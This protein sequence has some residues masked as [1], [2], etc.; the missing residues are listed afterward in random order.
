MNLRITGDEAA[1]LASEACLPCHEPVFEV[2]VESDGIYLSYDSGHD[3]TKD[4][5]TFQKEWKL[6]PMGSFVKPMSMMDPENVAI[7]AGILRDK[8]E[9]E[10]GLPTAEQA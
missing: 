1:R 9:I 7:L 5:H 3:Y 2:T 4:G 10:R 6:W 8:E